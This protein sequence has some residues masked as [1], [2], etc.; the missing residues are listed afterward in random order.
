MTQR[1]DIRACLADHPIML[2][3]NPREAFFGDHTNT[4][5]LYAVVDPEKEEEIL[6]VDVTSLYPWVNKY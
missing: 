6:Y 4:A 2:P 1:E 3:L 5:V